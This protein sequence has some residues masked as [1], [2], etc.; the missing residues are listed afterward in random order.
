MGD[1]AGRDD[2]ERGRTPDAGEV[3]SRPVR[4]ES[5]P[6]DIRSRAAD[7]PWRELLVSWLAGEGTP[8]PHRPRHA[9]SPLRRLM[10][11]AAPKA[12]DTAGVP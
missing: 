12:P 5:A 4:P 2:A 1:Y 9:A 11:G 7:A 8:P 3:P 10:G 6:Q